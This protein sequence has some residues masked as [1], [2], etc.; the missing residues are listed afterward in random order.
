M[1]AIWDL[2]AQ[3][4]S[5]WQAAEQASPEQAAEKLWGERCVPAAVVVQSAGERGSGHDNGA[6]TVSA[7]IRCASK[8][9]QAGG[10]WSVF[11]G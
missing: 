7:C 11:W 8:L 4:G 6:G 2:H 1:R 3:I 10:H 9:L 5:N